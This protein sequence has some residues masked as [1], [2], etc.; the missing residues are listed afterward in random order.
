MLI[1]FP[2]PLSTKQYLYQAQEVTWPLRQEKQQNKL[3]QENLM[4]KLQKIEI[5]D[6]EKLKTIHCHYKLCGDQLSNPIRLSLAPRQKLSKQMR[7]TSRFM[8]KFVRFVLLQ[9]FKT[10]V[11]SKKICSNLLLNSREAARPLGWRKSKDK[12]IQT[13]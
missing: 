8:K 9:C 13:K 7:K 6:I 2:L 10:I 3:F 12:I 1:I 11:L 5:C 4:K